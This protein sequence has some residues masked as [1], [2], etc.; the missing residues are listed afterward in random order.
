MNG[1]ILN[2]LRNW[3]FAVIAIPLQ[4]SSPR[5]L[6]KKLSCRREAA[7]CFTSLNVL[8]SHSGSLEKTAL[9]RALCK[10]LLVFHCNCLYLAQFI[11]Y[12]ASNNGMTLKYGIRV[13]QGHWKWHHSIDRIGVPIGVPVTMA[14]SCIISEVKRDIGQKS[15]FLDT[16]ATFDIPIWGDSRRNIATKF[17]A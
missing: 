9:S 14:V 16:L 15:R 5:Y 17:G 8:L 12:S 2:M 1:W 6:D 11:R 13:V 10:S 3:C 7:W 4:I